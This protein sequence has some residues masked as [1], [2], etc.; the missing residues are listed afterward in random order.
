LHK[1]L[2]CTVIND[3]DIGSWGTIHCQIN[4]GHIKIP[5]GF[6]DPKTLVTKQRFSKACV[7][8]PDNS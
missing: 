3:H 4:G 8:R 5:Q 1:N 2:S 6:D 7:A